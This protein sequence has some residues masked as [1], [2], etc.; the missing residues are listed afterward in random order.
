M[1][2]SKE[3]SI[4]AD[5]L[6]SVLTYGVCVHNDF[7]PASAIDNIKFSEELTRRSYIFDAYARNCKAIPS[8]NHK[9]HHESSY[10]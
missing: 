8:I 7:I 10:H 6:C 2:V 9:Q 4:A 3:G 5:N 1:E